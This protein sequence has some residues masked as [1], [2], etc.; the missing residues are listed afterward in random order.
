MSK[1]AVVT[2]GTRGIGA[3]I[4]KALKEAGYTAVATYAGNDQAAQA[5]SDETAIPTYK[6]DVSDPDACKQAVSK[7]NADLGQVDIH[8]RVKVRI[9]EIVDGIPQMTVYETTVGRALLWE[10]MPAGLSFH[11]I[12]EVIDEFDAVGR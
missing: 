1:I 11:M 8:A 2:G 4:S 7:I 5:F 3:A 9:E 10:I 12:N 6:F